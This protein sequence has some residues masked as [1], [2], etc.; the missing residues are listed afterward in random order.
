MSE[1]REAEAVDERGLGIALRQALKRL[2]ALVHIMV[3][4]RVVDPWTPAIK[5][6]QPRNPVTTGPPTTY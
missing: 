5:D 6:L 2:K 4:G 1:C 3:C